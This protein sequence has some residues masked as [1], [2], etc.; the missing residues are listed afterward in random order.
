MSQAVKHRMELQSGSLRATGLLGGVAGLLFLFGLAVTFRDR[1]KSSFLWDEGFLATSLAFMAVLV[2]VAAW[3]SRCEISLRHRSEAELRKSHEEL[4]RRVAERTAELRQH[5]E[6]LADF[7]ENAT[8]GLLIVG[9]DGTVLRA[10]RAEVAMLGYTPEEYVGRQITSFYEDPLR[11]TEFLW[12]LNNRETLED[13]LAVLRHRDG[14]VRHVLVNASVRFKDDRFMHARCFTRDV[15]DS[16][17]ADARLK[18]SLREVGEL[19]AALDQHAMVAITDPTG[20]I[21]YVNDRFC[22]VSKYSREELLGQ[23]HRILNSGHH[24]HD[25]MRGLWSTI[26]SGKIW[27]GEIRNRAKDGSLYWEDT[28]IVP[29]LGFD[30]RPQQY[31]AIR[32]DISARKRAQM[33]VE[34]ISERLRLATAGSGVG[35]W[36]WD[37]R[38]NTLIWDEYMCRLYGFTPDRFAGNH[39]AW[40]ECLHP[41]DHARACQELQ[42]AL[43]GLPSYDTSFRIVRADGELRHIRAHGVVSR[44]AAG[45]AVRMTGTNWD[46]TDQKVAEERLAASLHEKEVLLKE[47]HHRVK[48]NMQV[49]CSLL[50][51]QSEQ[52]REPRALAAFRESQ[53]RVK[54]MALLHE[55]LYQSESLSRINF[56][57]Y[58]HGLLDYLFSSFGSRA[59]HIHREVDVQNVSLSLDTAIPCGLI[60]SE[61]ACNSLKYAFADRDSGEVSVTMAQEADGLYH[62]RFRD[63][64]V[65]LPKDLDWRQSG[66]LGLQL[67]N[68]L[69][70]QL[71]GTLEYRNGVGAEF[72]LTFQERTPAT[73]ET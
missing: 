59:I 43:A 34:T 60:V 4:E 33:E 66:T 42:A 8:V 30:G 18:A 51:L 54:S 37:V 17:R 49:V 15:T 5:E 2:V 13:Y 9:P 21:T 35:I 56:A 61:L 22:E 53:F 40:A 47:I 25:F 1:I 31:V 73:K 12:R 65:G 28:T 48:N 23:D 14:S 64:G 41:D 70:N 24:T 39:E 11:G 45:R 69:T 72:H 7:F 6:E 55:K 63:N 20:R 29:F 67:V 52:I 44:D 62:L 3:R 38:Q 16:V 27:K 19:K 10:N 32:T 50:N 46:I 68:M 57:D 26:R 36:D 58:L 71:H